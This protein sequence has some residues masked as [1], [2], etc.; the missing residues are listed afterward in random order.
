M[1]IMRINPQMEITKMKQDKPNE[2]LFRQ[3][4]RN[5]Q[6]ACIRAKNPLWKLMWDEKLEELIENER[7]RLE[8]L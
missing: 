1:L 2:L 3:R 7:T 8:A 4:A 6:Q 5:L